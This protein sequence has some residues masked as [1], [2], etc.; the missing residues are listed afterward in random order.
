VY[1]NPFSG[2]VLSVQDE[3]NGFFNIV[4]FIHWSFLLNSD[5]GKYVVGIPVLI[6]L[7]MLISGIVLWWPRNKAARKQRF[8]FQWKNIR[9]WKR[10]NYDLLCILGFYAS[11]IALIVAITGLFYSFVFIQ[12]FM[13]F[14]FSGG[15]TV[16]PEFAHI[17]T[18]DPVEMKTAATID[19]IAMQ[20]EQHYPD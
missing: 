8:W 7:F 16:Y 4:K 5:W 2:E 15:N 13:Y 20:V 10:Q 3:K 6:F 19:K 9:N 1:V 17:Q 12:A 18:E 14:V 11:F